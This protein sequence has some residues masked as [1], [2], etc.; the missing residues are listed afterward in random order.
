V[1]QVCKACLLDYENKNPLPSL[2]AYIITSRNLAQ[3]FLIWWLKYLENSKTLQLQRE[4]EYSELCPH[5]DYE[6][7]C[8]GPAI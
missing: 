5:D 1:G 2:D 3:F 6:D 7:G 8:R 4:L